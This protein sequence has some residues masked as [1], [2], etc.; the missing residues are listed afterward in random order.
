MS[1]YGAI[2][3]TTLNPI[4]PIGCD[5]EYVCIGLYWFTMKGFLEFV[6]KVEGIQEQCWN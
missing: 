1:L 6:S 2:T 3:I 4:Q 5:K